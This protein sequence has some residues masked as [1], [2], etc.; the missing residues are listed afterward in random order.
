MSLSARDLEP[1]SSLESGCLR[2]AAFPR[3]VSVAYNFM[4]PLVWNK[5][6]DLHSYEAVVP[7]C[8]DVIRTLDFGYWDAQAKSVLPFVTVDGQTLRMMPISVEYGGERLLLSHTWFL[9]REA[10]SSQQGGFKVW[11]GLYPHATW[12]SRPTVDLTWGLGR[13]SVSD[14]ECGAGPFCFNQV[15]SGSLFD[16]KVIFEAGACCW[17][18]TH[19][20]VSGFLLNTDARPFFDKGAALVSCQEGADN[21][22]SVQA[23]P[24]RLQQHDP[25]GRCPRHRG[26]WRR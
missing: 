13:E 3:E 5:R 10:H 16:L 7:R 14:S 6:A 12:S 8:M 20:M 11:R 22:P 26:R 17:L 4:H 9:D 21:Q 25:R 2:L 23:L 15:G 24:V 19:M 1:V 18:P